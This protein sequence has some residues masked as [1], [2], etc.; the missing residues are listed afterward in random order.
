MAYDI[1]KMKLTDASGIIAHKQQVTA[2]NPDTL[3]TAIE[4]RTITV[5]EEEATIQSL[6]P[7]DL[8]IV[9]VDGDK[10]IG[11]LNLRQDHRKK[12]EHIG[13]FGISLQ[14]AYTGFG[15]GTR[16]VEQ[17][18]EFARDNEKL[19][20]LI[21]TVFAN[22]PGAIKLYKRLG[23]EEEA[24]LKKQVKLADGYTDLVYMANFLE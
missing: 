20:K 16:M 21:L 6:G 9:A 7:N 4:N 23:F 19:E 14:K 10:V 24:T 13:Q 3:A 17:A 22:N 12:F 2:E 8:G 15:T 18:V 11:M 1:R 5:E